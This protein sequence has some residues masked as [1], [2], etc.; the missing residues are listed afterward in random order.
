MLPDNRHREVRAVLAAVFFRQRET[1]V[2]R[3]VGAPAHFAEQRFPFMT[4]QAAPLEVGPRPF[5]AMVE[6]TDIVVLAFERLDFAL[7]KVV[8]FRKVILDLSRDVEIHRDTLLSGQGTN[9]E[10]L[11][12]CGLPRNPDNPRHPGGALRSRAKTR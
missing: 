8:Q 6:K 11:T 2:S 3:L 5:A 1:V 12:E 7:D 4:R 10:C 9:L